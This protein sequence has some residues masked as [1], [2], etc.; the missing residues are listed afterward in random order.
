[1]FMN[2]NFLSYFEKD[3]HEVKKIIYSNLKSRNENVNTLTNALALENGK[4]ARALF[5]LMGS[6]FGK[7]EKKQVLHLAAG[8]ETLHLA[9]LV[10]D[11]IVDESDLRR[12]KITLNAS[13]G[14]KS[15]LFMGDYLFSKAYILFSK[16]ASPKSISNVSNTIK[17]ICQGE[18]DQFLCSYSLSTSVKQYLR[19]ID[20]KCASLFSLSIYIGAYQ[21]GARE[22]VSK[23]L[24]KIGY[25][26]GM[27]FQ[28]VD[29]ILDIS[30]PK[31]SSLGKPTEND[32]KKGIYSLP[33]ILEIKNNNKALIEAL[34]N[35]SHEEAINIIKTSWG[36]EK[37]KNVAKK[38]TEKALALIEE[39]PSNT[40]K[41]ALKN[42]VQ[43]LLLRSF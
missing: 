8:I 41:N 27:A 11:D 40:E 4:M 24:K 12:G 19:R 35:N 31:A 18:I 15:A 13:Y 34:E 17:I 37:S 25:Y 38:Y 2:D 14:T 33:V 22:N 36:L 21:S 32:I 28:L 39:L 7:P 29:D 5:V 43:F 30:S 9:T 42:L 6:S 3:L 10:H 1:M 26:V 23:K 20:A 16:H